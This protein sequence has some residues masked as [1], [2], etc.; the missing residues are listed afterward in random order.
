[1]WPFILTRTIITERPILA[2]K[3]DLLKI[4]HDPQQVLAHNA[5]V[6]SVVQDA[7][8]PSWYTVTDRLSVIG[9][10]TTHTTARSKWTETT[11][12]CDIEVYADL[13]TR[14]KVEIRVREV[15]SSEGTV[16]FHERVVVKGLFIF[17]PFIVSTIIK[18]HRE[19]MDAIAANLESG[20][21]VSSL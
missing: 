4:L 3:N 7:S 21:R 6:V 15:E 5:M 13:W 19:Y 20:H 10:W 18:G 9:S 11:D 12:G 14:S 16:L 2:S 1:M 17:I 8:D